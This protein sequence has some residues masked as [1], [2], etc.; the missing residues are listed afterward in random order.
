MPSAF[1]SGF[2]QYGDRR[3]MEP[4]PIEGWQ[5]QSWEDLHDL[6]KACRQKISGWRSIIGAVG[7]EL[8]DGA[9]DL[10]QKSW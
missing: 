6:T 7:N 9:T 3:Q 5:R 2:L 10:V 4:A 8:L 1:C